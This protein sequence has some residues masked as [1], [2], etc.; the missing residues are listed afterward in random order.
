M[1]DRLLIKVS[2][3]IN[4]TNNIQNIKQDHRTFVK[5]FNDNLKE[6]HFLNVKERK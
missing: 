1:L 3:M 6:I 2:N 5:T 4:K